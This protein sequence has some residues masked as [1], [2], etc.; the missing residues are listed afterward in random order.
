MGYL[1]NRTH[2]SPSR[3]VL[4]V[5]V[6]LKFQQDLRLFIDAAADFSK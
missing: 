4:P 5:T 6:G 1:W 2:C 3:Q